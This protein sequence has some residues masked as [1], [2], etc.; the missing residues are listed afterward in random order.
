MGAYVVVVSLLTG[1]FLPDVAGARAGAVGGCSRSPT[2]RRRAGSRTMF[3]PCSGGEPEC[4]VAD[5]VVEGGADAPVPLITVLRHAA[6]RGLRPDRHRNEII[7]D[8]P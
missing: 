2:G 8:L 3:L 6:W 7:A 5:V 1:A 4:F